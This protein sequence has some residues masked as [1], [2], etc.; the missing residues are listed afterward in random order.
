MQVRQVMPV[1][2]G[3]LTLLYPQWLPGTHSP[4]GRVVRLS[5]LQIT[6]DGKPLAWT[7]NPL[8]VFAFHM[9]VPP[10]VA[11]LNLVFQH[12]SPVTSATDRVVM[13]PEIVNLQ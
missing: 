5:G 2:A 6:A 9:T 8:D 4:R 11:S 3:P 1:T 13:T 12:L 10:G 7:R